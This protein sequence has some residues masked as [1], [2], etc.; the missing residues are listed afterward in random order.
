MQA[1]VVKLQLILYVLNYRNNNI[2]NLIYWYMIEMSY[3]QLE[4]R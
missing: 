4:H 1:A 2:K 3:I